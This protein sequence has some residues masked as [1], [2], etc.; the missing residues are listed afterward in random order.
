MPDTPAATPVPPKRLFLYALALM[1]LMSLPFLYLYFHIDTPLSGICMYAVWVVDS[2]VMIFHEYGHMVT[3]WLFGHP[4]GMRFFPG[5]GGALTYFAPQSPWMLA[6]IYVAGALLAA[7]LYLKTRT[8]A[9]CILAALA[10]AHVVFAFTPLHRA[11]AMLMGQGAEMLAGTLCAYA[12][13]FR[14]KR[15]TKADAIIADAAWRT[16]GA[17]GGLYAI[18]ERMMH[19]VPMLLDWPRAMTFAP[20]GDHRRLFNDTE[21]A[22]Y[23]LG[24]NL[25]AAAGIVF[26]FGAG[27]IGFIGYKAVFSKRTTAST[28][29]M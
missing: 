4:A 20:N 3:Q 29:A 26:L 7:W 16:G 13:L 1:P 10:A 21:L 6:M 25:P 15:W 9:L 18:W 2:F 14:G 22:A 11:L 24:L 27:C 8:R 17:A 5:E 23:T 12:C 19:T 28:A